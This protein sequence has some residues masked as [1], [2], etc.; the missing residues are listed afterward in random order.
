MRKGRGTIMA[1]MDLFNH[2]GK[3]AVIIGGKIG[4]VIYANNESALAID[5]EEERS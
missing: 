1:A 5:E 3:T 2:S 4:I